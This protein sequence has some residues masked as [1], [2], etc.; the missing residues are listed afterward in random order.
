M[1]EF[2][3]YYI[4]VLVV[5]SIIGCLLLLR[6][7]MNMHTDDEDDGEST[8]HVWDG[9]LK[10]LNNPLPKWWLNVFYMSIIFS[11]VYLVLYPGMGNFP[12]VLGWTQT[13]QYD[14]EVA[15]SNERFKDI[16]A[17][18][19]DKS[20]AELVTDADAVRLGRNTYMN[21]CASCHGSDARGAKSF[22]NLTDDDWLYGG[23]A[24]TVQLTI[25]NGR[26]GNMPAL[27]AVAG[28]EGT[29][30]IIDWLL[31]ETAPGSAEEA[32]AKNKFLTSSCVGCHGMTGEGNPML[33]AP[34]L[35]DD[36]WLHGGTREDIR[37]VITNGRVN[38]MPAH[39]ELIGEDRVK[40]VT[41]YV[42][43]LSNK[44]SP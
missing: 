15:A 44:A 42:L 7:T 23:D 43:S 33:G 39:L 29:E 40:L 27:G 41:A 37:D 6:W 36:I 26:M 19:T 28:P 18:F 2:W 16:Y 9:D 24:A 5:L 12:G 20:A 30:L 31:N 22:P 1:S 21:F 32:A 13:G 11:V 25:A 10:E 34:N 38:Q 14:A 17:A 35:R 4:I 8:G 3:S